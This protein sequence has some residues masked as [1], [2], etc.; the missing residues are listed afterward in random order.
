MQSFDEPEKG[1]PDAKTVPSFS[2]INVLSP[3]IISASAYFF[4]S[5]ACVD[6]PIEQG[7]VNRIALPSFSTND[8]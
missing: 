4:Q 8:E 3:L 2:K 5:S 1:I 6:L 7:P